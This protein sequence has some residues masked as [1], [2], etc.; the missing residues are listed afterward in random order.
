M[1]RA[2]RDLSRVRHCR[3]AD[4]SDTAWPRRKRHGYADRARLRRKISGVT[5]VMALAGGG[6]EIRALQNHDPPVAALNRMGIL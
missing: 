5:H 1:R 2:D 3:L 4:S 6:G